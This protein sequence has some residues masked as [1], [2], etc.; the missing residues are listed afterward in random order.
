MPQ[1][2]PKSGKSLRIFHAKFIFSQFEDHNSENV[3][4]E[5]TPKHPVNSL[6]LTV[7][8]NLILEK[9]GNPVPYENSGWRKQLCCIGRRCIG[10]VTRSTLNHLSISKSE[11]VDDVT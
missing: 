5:H 3:L 8:L 7:V 10:N 6:R 4:G 1:N 2:S 11:S 9:S